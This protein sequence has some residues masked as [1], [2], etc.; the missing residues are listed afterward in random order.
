MQ[1]LIDP[2]K[3][4]EKL[5][6]KEELLT[7]TIQKLKQ[8]MV[9]SDYETKVPAEV[10][11]LNQEKLVNNEGELERLAEAMQTLKLML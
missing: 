7:G 3:E 10:Q 2:Q 6:K 4:L 11:K 9:A 8:A 5:G 1:G